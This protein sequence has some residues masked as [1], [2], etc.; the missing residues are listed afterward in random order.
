MLY[1]NRINLSEG[2][3][4]AKS[5]SNKECLVCHDLFFNHGFKIQYSV[6]NGCHGLMIL[7]LYIGDIDYPCIINDIS[8]SEAIHLLKSFVLDDRKYI[9]N[10]Y[11]KHQ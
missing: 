4:D 11:Q 3:G 9:Q 10:T 7:C 8:K 5:S 1:Y 6:S 2:I